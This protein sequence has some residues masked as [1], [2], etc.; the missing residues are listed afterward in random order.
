MCWTVAGRKLGGWNESTR[1]RSRSK[2]QDG[3]FNVESCG[4]VG[5]GTGSGDGLGED[6][7]DFGPL[8]RAHLYEG[9][10]WDRGGGWL[11]GDRGHRGV[12]LRPHPGIRTGGRRVR[13]ARGNKRGSGGERR[14][15]D[16]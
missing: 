15:R 2:G 10:A 16:I 9:R 4:V 13:L 8:V 1:G 12:R 11:D 14:G 6:L 5:G 7:K 3:R